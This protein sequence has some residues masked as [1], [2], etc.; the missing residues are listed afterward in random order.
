MYKYRAQYLRNYDGD[1]V[2]FRVDLGF[3]IFMDMTVRLAYINTYEL[4]D[5]DTDLRERGYVAKYRVKELL[6]GA[7]EIIIETDK[8]KTGKYGRYLAEVY[9]DGVNLGQQL[10]DEDLAEIYK[11]N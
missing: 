11:G 4:Q 9:Y 2:R 7:K 5:A 3:S 6:E 1:T 8:D 10:M